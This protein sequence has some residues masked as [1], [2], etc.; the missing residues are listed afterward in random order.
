MVTLSALVSG[1]DA[2]LVR[3]GY[4]GSTMV[5]YRGYWRR[6]EKFF[7]ARGVEEFSRDLALAWV[8]EACGFFDKEQAGALKQTDVYLFRVAAMLDDYAVHGAV[9]RRYSRAISKVSG[10]GADTVARFQGWLQAAG[11]AVSTVRTYAT[12]AGEFVAFLDT[13]GWTARCDA[14]A[15]DAFV[16]T[17]A[18]YQFKTVEQKLCALRSFLRFASGDGLVDAALLD[19][20]PAVKSRKQTRI[21]SVW[22][23]AD[24]TK[25]LDAVDRGNPCGKRDY[26]II[27]LVTRL[28]LRGI[29][30]KRL[31]FC[32]FDWPGNRLSVVQVKTG[33]RVHLP[34]LKD[35]GWAVIDYIRCGRPVSDCPQV[36]I[37]H[38]API[39][40]FS[41]QD[42]LHQILVKHARA[43]HVPVSEKRRHGMH[44]LR[45]TLATRL[46]ED[47]TPVEQIADILGHQSVRST[48]AYLKSSLGLLAK[49]ALEPDRP[50][51]QAS[52]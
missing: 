15:L 9:L 30:V 22:D 21:P 34:L 4:K 42:H 32:D 26:A 25:V 29:D 43:A 37:R 19:A 23:P 5:W 52:R 3:L 6:L 14:G 13:R 2:E 20:V 41:D 48:G 39:G 10:D 33:H 38:T 50:A 18:G 1:L 24:V 8:D 46:M 51:R 49:C 36:F 27:L 44:S 35:V 31:E 17:L 12:V 7:A 28:G 47:G 40:P 16:A 11:C 45:H